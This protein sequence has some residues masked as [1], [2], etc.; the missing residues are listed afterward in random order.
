MV[1][2]KGDT[3]GGNPGESDYW[4]WFIDFIDSQSRMM[5]DMRGKITQSLREALCLSMS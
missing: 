4:G 2:K 5:Q 3:K 1:L